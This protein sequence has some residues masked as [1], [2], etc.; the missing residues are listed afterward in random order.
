[1]PQQQEFLRRRAE[2]THQ[3]VHD[4]LGQR[5]LELPAD[6]GDV[7]GRV[8]RDGAQ[9]PVVVRPVRNHVR[10]R[11]PVQRQRQPA[12]LHAPGPRRTVTPPVPIRPDPGSEGSS[13]DADYI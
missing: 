1:M 10:H 2:A 7:G 3:A 12:P 9:V 13:T 5:V 8:R 6:V 11:P 4:G